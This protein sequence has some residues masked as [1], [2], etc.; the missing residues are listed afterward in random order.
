MILIKTEDELDG[1]R[2]S[3]RLAATVR[4]EICQW[5]RPG[6]TTYEVGEYAGQLIQNGGGECAFLGYRGF[7]GKICVSIND[8]V[9]HGVPGDRR[10]DIGDVVSLD[11]G[12]LQNG[13][14][15]DTAATVMVGVTDP[16]KIRMVKTAEQAL[17]RGI[18]K[19]VSGNRLSD[20]SNAIQ[21]TVES[22]GFSVVRDFVGHGI[23]RSLHEDPQVANFGSPGKGPRLRPG[24]TLAIEPMVNMGKAA[25]K[26]MKDGWTVRTKDRLPSAHVEHMIA[27]RREGGPEILTL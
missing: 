5:I 22:E 11:I 6:V 18:E 7:P 17:A 1:L 16:D 4:K 21:V 12:V 2:R 20:I 13:F 23:G 19:A 3:A 10:I 9:V 24:M 8:E 14:Y 27:I 25:V 15:G 26:V